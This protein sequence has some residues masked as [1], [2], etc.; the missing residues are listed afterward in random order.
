MDSLG[1]FCNEKGYLTDGSG[2]IIDRSGKLLFN[3]N[4]LKSGEFIK[5]FPFSKFS[6]ARIQGDIGTTPNGNPIL[7]KQPNGSY[8]DKKG[9][10]INV[11]GYLVDRFGNVID[12]FGKPM[13][14]KVILEP[15]GEIPFVFRTGLLR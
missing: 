15:D 9:K 13:F 10:L 2:N 11:R 14:D 8:I 7:E 5:I 1:R 6:I 4:D 3:K 12:K